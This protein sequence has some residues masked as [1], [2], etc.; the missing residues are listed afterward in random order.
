MTTT[1]NLQRRKM[2]FAQV[3]IF[4]VIC[5]VG[6]SEDAITTISGD[7]SLAYNKMNQQSRLPEMKQRLRHLETTDTNHENHYDVNSKDTKP[8]RQRVTTQSLPIFNLLAKAANSNNNSNT[9]QVDQ[10][11]VTTTV[12]NHS[13]HTL[14][15]EE[16]IAQGNTVLEQQQ[17]NVTRASIH[18]LQ[19]EE[20][21]EEQNR[22][23]RPN[24][25]H[26]INNEKQNH[27]FGSHARYQNIKT[28]QDE[29]QIDFPYSDEASASITTT[30][31]TVEIQ[32]GIY[33]DPINDIVYD[34]PLNQ[35]II[36]DENGNMNEIPSNFFYYSLY[37]MDNQ[38]KGKGKGGKGSGDSS[39]K[40][41]KSS[42]GKGGKGKDGS[43]IVP[44]PKDSNCID[45]TWNDMI[46]CK[47]KSKLFC[48][49]FKSL[50]K[51]NL[52]VCSRELLLCI[53]TKNH[54]HILYLAIFLSIYRIIEKERQG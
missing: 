19:D 12:V 28:L 33:Y 16:M 20:M 25:I 31:T 52:M 2:W 15:D 22:Y 44:D 51:F 46:Y 32:D 34:A 3:I 50:S 24:G 37:T 27:Q 13:I 10:Q 17:Q 1:L 6:A 43:I 54:S 30:T 29:K 49:C 53:P 5:I 40:S 21:I 48:F 39:K 14:Q 45:D 9:E 47:T 42:K 8:Q 11:N 23:K 18:T 36:S 4:Y 38:G 41:S 35:Q 7:N 26:D